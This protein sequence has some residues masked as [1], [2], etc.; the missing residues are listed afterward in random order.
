MEANTLQ[1]ATFV[2]MPRAG[3]RGQKTRG[4]IA[5]TFGN[6]RRAAPLN[7]HLV[8]LYLCVSLFQEGCV[9]QSLADR[10][11]NKEACSLSL[12]SAGPNKNKAF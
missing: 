1:G 7:L 3:K 5:T 4:G 9:S 12:E 10:T 8:S 11:E 6:I 2:Q